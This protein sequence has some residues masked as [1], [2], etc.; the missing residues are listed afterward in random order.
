MARGVA[1]CE[2]LARDLSA[3]LDGALP[4]ERAARLARHLDR[5]PSCRARYEK[6]KAL[7]ERLRGVR[8][9]PTP[10]QLRRRIREDLEE[11]DRRDREPGAPDA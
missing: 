6:E 8:P 7:V 9:P 4:P 5:C 3:H 1:T 2:E 11:E 10:A